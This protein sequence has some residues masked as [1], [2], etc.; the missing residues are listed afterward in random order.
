MQKTLIY[1]FIVLVIILKSTVYNYAQTGQEANNLRK[2]GVF[3]SQAS[4]AV[5][6][7]KAKPLKGIKLTQKERDLKDAIND[8]DSTKKD[9]TSTNGI[10]G[11][12]VE[13][14]YKLKEKY[15]WD[16]DSSLYDYGEDI[17]KYIKAYSGVINKS[18]DSLK[19]EKYVAEKY[20]GYYRLS[21]LLRD[22]VK[23]KNAS[24]LAEFERY[25]GIMKQLFSKK[26]TTKE[27]IDAIEKKFED[28]KNYWIWLISNYKT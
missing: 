3:S 24:V 26:T 4:N 6:E 15:W 23:P 19:L 10:D 21:A 12:I 25:K 20:K 2:L 16:S 14:K 1:S 17:E 27:Q 28:K 9:D 22:K 7:I 18:E 11:K 8:E 5:I 13:R